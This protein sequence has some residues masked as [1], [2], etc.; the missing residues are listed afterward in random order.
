VIATWAGLRPLLASDADAPG[1]VSREHHVVTRPEG[2][3][4]IA[5][6]K[7]TTYRRMAKEAVDAVVKLLAATNGHATVAACATQARPLPGARGL[8]SGN[9]ED[10]VAAMARR[11]AA[12][13]PI[14]PRVA[15]HL[16]QTY[17]V[18]APAVLGRGLDDPGLLTRIDPELPYLWA[19]VHHAA[20]HELVRTVEDVLVRRIPL[21][22]RSRDQGVHAADR[23]ADVLQAALGWSTEERARH[24]DRFHAYVASTRAYRTTS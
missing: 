19:E 2:V 10:P 6:G 16:A 3:V 24:L 17:G 4:M 9:G 18:N 23:V 13:A 11:L 8:T 7:L 20:A 1:A 21:C 12:L 22:L 15:T 14:G 5:G